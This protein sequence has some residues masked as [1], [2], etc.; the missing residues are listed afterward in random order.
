VAPAPI[1]DG[2]W[3]LP[4]TG[5]DRPIL[6]TSH[7]INTA[8]LSKSM[9]LVT[10]KTDRSLPMPSEPR[11]SIRAATVCFDFGIMTFSNKWMAS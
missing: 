1:A 11:T 9:V 10:A 3:T 5:D 7:A 6:Q 8:W 4:A 2:K